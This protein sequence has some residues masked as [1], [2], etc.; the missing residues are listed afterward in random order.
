MLLS[1]KAQ[2]ILDPC[3]NY[4]EEDNYQRSTA[5]TLPKNAKA[6]NCDRPFRRGWYRFT[7]GAGE[8]IPTHCPK[9]YSCGM[10]DVN[11]ILILKLRS[12]IVWLKQLSLKF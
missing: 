12:L 6:K 11:L 4:I 10:F 2:F 7:S 9:E 5:F 1:G 8:F 3:K